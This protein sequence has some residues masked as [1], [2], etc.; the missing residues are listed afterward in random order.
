MRNHNT[1]W[2]LSRLM[3]KPNLL[4]FEAHLLNRART[5][6]ETAN[7]YAKE[8]FFGDEDFE[9]EVVEDEEMEDSMTEASSAN[10]LDEEVEDITLTQVRQQNVA[11]RHAR[12]IRSNEDDLGDF[13]ADDDSDIDVSDVTSSEEEA[14]MTDDA[15][16]DGTNSDEMNDK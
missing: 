9:D 3:L 13:V 14:K 11:T 5:G 6:E 12:P 16:S 4:V 8:V 7:G 1:L 10:A 15:A 2:Q